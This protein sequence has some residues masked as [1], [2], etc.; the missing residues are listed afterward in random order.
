MLNTQ[1]IFEIAQANNDAELMNMARTYSDAHK[2]AYGFRPRGHEFHS[3]EG[4]IREYNEIVEDVCASIRREEA[5]KIEAR[6]NFESWIEGT[7][8]A[9]AGDRLTALKWILQA[10]GME[11]DF[12]FYGWDILEH[13]HGVGYGYIKSTL[14][15]SQAA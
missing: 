12:S 13:A 5:E 10:E 1:A 15:Q 4:F 14:E 2:D 11:R 7:I 9:G 8:A 3:L 6:K